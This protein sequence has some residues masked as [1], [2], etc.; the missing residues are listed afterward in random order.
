LA[1]ITEEIAGTYTVDVVSVKFYDVINDERYGYEHIMT[2]A[3]GFCFN[4]KDVAVSA[5][6]GALDQTELLGKT[7]G[8]YVAIYQGHDVP[9][10]KPW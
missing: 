8:C 6:R 7:Y 10:L 9:D 5:L 3:T 4:E 2:N 1:S